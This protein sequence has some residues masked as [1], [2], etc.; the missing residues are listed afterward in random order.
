VKWEV[1]GLNF[2]A[3]IL[4]FGFWS[5]EFGFLELGH[6][7]LVIENFILFE[8]GQKHGQRTG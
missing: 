5:L 7:K 3:W 8:I 4:D 2:G 1:W 6:L